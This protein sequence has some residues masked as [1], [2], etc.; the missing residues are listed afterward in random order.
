MR[1]KVFTNS[2]G[3]KK[4]FGVGG[5]ERHSGSE[6]RDDER[7]PLWEITPGT[8]QNSAVQKSWPDMNAQNSKARW[9]PT[10]LHT[11]TCRWTS[12][13]LVWAQFIQKELLIFSK[14][15]LKHDR[16]LTFLQPGSCVVLGFIAGQVTS[17]GGFIFFSLKALYGYILARWLNYKWPLSPLTCHLPEFKVLSLSLRSFQHHRE[18]PLSHSRSQMWTH[19][20]TRMFHHHDLHSGRI[21]SSSSSAKIIFRK[22]TS[23]WN[24]LPLS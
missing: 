19:S 4:I 21:L 8:A 2:L 13:I 5:W 17:I 10:G 6:C 15:C 18:P 20:V 3:E 23:G 1:I 11:E 12:M 24:A 7:L 22:A 16:Y 14:S 9:K